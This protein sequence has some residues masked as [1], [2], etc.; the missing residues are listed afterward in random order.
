MKHEDYVAH[1]AFS[2]DGRRVVTASR[3]KTARVWD[4]ESGQPVTP[5]MKHE[6][7]VNHAAFSPDGRRVVT[8]SEDKT[9][10]VWDAGIGTARHAADEA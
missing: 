5:P 2:P 10:R 1:A 8:A 3:D 4:A 6:D 9:A 7:M